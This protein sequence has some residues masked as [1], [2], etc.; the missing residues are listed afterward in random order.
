MLASFCLSFVFT[1]KIY[2]SS[3]ILC[4]YQGYLGCFSFS[5]LPYPTEILP[6]AFRNYLAC[7]M[8]CLSKPTITFSSG[9]SP[10]IL[11]VILSAYLVASLPDNASYFLSPNIGLLLSGPFLR[12]AHHPGQVIFQPAVFR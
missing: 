5:R 12:K 8:D 10:E 1:R 2:L 11:W 4:S 3:R 7:S 9:K 6:F